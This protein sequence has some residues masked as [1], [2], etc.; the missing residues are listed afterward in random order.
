MSMSEEALQIKREIEREYQRQWRKK[1]P[2]KVKRN[3]EQF[4]ERKAAE[5]KAAAAQSDKG[6]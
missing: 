2:D 4:W 5:M 1:N 6:Q 3:R